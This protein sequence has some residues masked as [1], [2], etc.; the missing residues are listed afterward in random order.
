MSTQNLISPSFSNATREAFNNTWKLSVLAYV[1]QDNINVNST[2]TYL[3][4]Q[5]AEFQIQGSTDSVELVNQS[6]SVVWSSVLSMLIRLVNVTQNEEF[7]GFDLIPDSAMSVPGNY[8]IVVLP[9]L[10]S[11]NDTSLGQQLEV[12]M[13]ISESYPPPPVTVATGSTAPTPPTGNLV[14]T[15]NVAYSYDDIAANFVVGNFS[16]QYLSQNEHTLSGADTGQFAFIFN[17]TSPNGVSDMLSYLWSPPCSLNIGFECVSNSSWVLPTPENSS[18]VS[19]LPA[20]LRILWYTNTT[21]FY[22]AF[23]EWDQIL[24]TTSTTMAAPEI[25]S[26]TTLDVSNGSAAC[27][28]LAG[29]GSAS[30][31]SNTCTVNGSERVSDFLMPRGFGLQIYPG[32]TLV[33]VG[34]G[35]ANYGSIVNNGTFDVET[36]FGSYGY[37]VNGGTISLNSSFGFANE[38]DNYFMPYGGTI[39]NWGTINVLPLYRTFP[40]NYTANGTT[41]YFPAGQLIGVQF[42]NDGIVNN[43]GLINNSGII[44]NYMDGSSYNSTINNLGRIIDQPGSE[45]QNVNDL[46][47]YGIITN[48]GNFT[49]EGVVADICGGGFM[50]TG[51]GTVSGVP[52]ITACS[53]AGVQV[54][55]AVQEKSSSSS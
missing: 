53:T 35:F 52:I 12:N 48:F 24:L 23:Q 55:T 26:W 42:A 36:A 8:T 45:F 34:G 11:S 15:K 22:V 32:V 44:Q 5:I 2:L 39:N 1:D 49:N 29:P 43:Y 31:Q 25:A 51:G 27:Q 18:V 21:G 17:V 47:N 40:V 7:P 19:Y 54:S 38:Y 28:N 20:I 16:I 3:S 30:W 41:F 9:L 4:T 10:K 6:G 50:N 14:M 46:Y 33:L 37:I 13:T